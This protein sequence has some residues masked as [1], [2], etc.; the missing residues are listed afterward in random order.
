MCV[1]V[2]DVSVQR[3]GGALQRPGKQGQLTSEAALIKT[4]RVRGQQ[5]KVLSERHQCVVATPV[6]HVTERRLHH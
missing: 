5:G 6:N 3:V 2:P 4:S 1:Y